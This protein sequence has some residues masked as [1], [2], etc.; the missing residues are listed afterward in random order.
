VEILV[1]CEPTQV[2]VRT[3][4]LAGPDRL[5]VD[6]LARPSAEDRPVVAR[7]APASGGAPPK[8]AASQESATPPAPKE[9]TPPQADR[10]A[11]PA[12]SPSP[13][14]KEVPSA[15]PAPSE[16]N[17]EENPAPLTIVLDPGHG[18]H[19][20]GAIGPTGLMEKDVAL[21]LALRLRRLLQ[22]RLGVRVRMTRTEDVFVS[23]PERT[24][25]ANQ[26]KA[27]FLVS[28]HV[29]A[30][31]A[32]GAVGFETFY[33]SREPSDN[34]ARAS[35]QQENLVIENNGATGKDLESL[36]KTTLADMAVTRDMKE[37]SNLAERILSSLEK[38][39]RVE[40]RGVKSGPFYVLATAAMPA[41][42][43]ESAFITNPREERRLQRDD[44]RQRIAHALYE[45]IAAYKIRYEQQLGL[46]NG[47][48]GVRS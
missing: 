31:S 20:P 44:Y 24:A 6:V 33:F 26:V 9:V 38:V 15:G 37:S 43:V 32:R 45:G 22:S 17:A 12:P 3:L 42:L 47:P 4:T 25:F 41:V 29:N 36:L 30:A 1:V 14:A 8:S 27:D 28:I 18:G 34:D 13:P 23:L 2:K 39:L 7:A 19:D 10:P 21:D 35:A 16:P 11:R 5:V 46:R 40:N 48:T